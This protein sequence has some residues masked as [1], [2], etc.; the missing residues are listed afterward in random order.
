M[1]IWLQKNA[2][3]PVLAKELLWEFEV[4]AAAHKRNDFYLIVGL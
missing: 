1:N 2:T 4:S 3:I